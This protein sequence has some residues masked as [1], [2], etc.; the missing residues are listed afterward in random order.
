[1]GDKDNLYTFS[2]KKDKPLAKV[3]LS[4]NFLEQTGIWA[5]GDCLLRRYD[6][7]NP[8]IGLIDIPGQKLPVRVHHQDFTIIG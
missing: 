8:D 4:S 3:V 6:S 5:D 7:A 2:P 1:M